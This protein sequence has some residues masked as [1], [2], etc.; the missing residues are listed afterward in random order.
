MIYHVISSEMVEF[1]N[2]DLFIKIRLIYLISVSK[3][4]MTLIVTIK[5]LI[6]TKELLE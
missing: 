5:T 3:L 6:C 4:I 2:L 1:M